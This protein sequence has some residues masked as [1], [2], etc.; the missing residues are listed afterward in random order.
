MS[1]EF[2]AFRLRPGKDDDIIAILDNIHDKTNFLKASIRV[3]RD[4]ML[5]KSPYDYET[6]NETT[7]RLLL[8]EAELNQ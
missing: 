1:K 4:Y 6:E 5:E 3:A 7:L 8:E 2:A